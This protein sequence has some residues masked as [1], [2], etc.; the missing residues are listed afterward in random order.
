[1][2]NLKKQGA[3]SN[4]NKFKIKLKTQYVKGGRGARKGTV[5]DLWTAR[6]GNQQ[7][8]QVVD[9]ITINIRKIFL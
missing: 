6:N 5:K 4:E 8:G 7:T 9:E 1:M 3:T 2:C